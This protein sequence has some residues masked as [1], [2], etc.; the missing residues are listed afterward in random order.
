VDV[1]GPSEELD[2]ASWDKALDIDVKGVF[3]CSQVVGREMI[4]QKRG[5]IIN[6]A[7]IYGLFGVPERAAYCSAK[8]E[9]I[10][11]MQAFACEWARHTISSG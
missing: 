5:N 4:K 11:L 3:L 9:V 10:S 7:S 1:V 6:I 8:A 2:E